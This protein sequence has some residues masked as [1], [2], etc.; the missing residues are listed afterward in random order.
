[1]CTEC[2]DTGTGQCRNINDQSGL[3]TPR[4]GQCVAEDQSAFGIGVDDLDS[5]AGHR[6]HHIARIGRTGIRFVFTS[7]HDSDDVEFEFQ[8]GRCLQRADD[9]GRP[10]HVVFHVLDVTDG[11]QR[12]S[13][14]V[15]GDPLADQRYR[16]NLFVGAP[17]FDHDQF[18]R[19]F[20]PGRYRQKCTHTQPLYLRTFEY[21]DRDV[22]VA[23]RDLLRCF[24]EV[25]RCAYV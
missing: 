3:E 6:R 16:W 20:R 9:T 22:F 4:I 2:H 11:L 8:L 1:M 21:L 23:F 18:W 14:G 12:D 15:E 7:R 13:T 5:L 25:I 10:T 24:G 17:V 19:S